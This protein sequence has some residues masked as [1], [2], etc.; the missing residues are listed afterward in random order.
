MQPDF[1]PAP[2]PP[3]D[4]YAFLN[5]TKRPSPL[6]S[7]LA[8]LSTRGKIVLGVGALILLIILLVVVKSILGS[9]AKSFNLTSLEGVLAQQQQIITLATTGSQQ[10]QVTSQSYMNFSYTAIASATTD[11]M[12]LIKLLSYNGVKVNPASYTFTTSAN[13]KLTQAGQTSTFDSLYA[14]VMAQ[15]LK[16]YQQALSNAYSLNKSTI[17]K[18]YL[19][20]DYKNTAVLIKMLGSSYG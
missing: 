13:T 2:P 8:N 15:Q 18:N 12:K 5:Q 3:S 10:Q 1:N 11:Q 4:P 17:V 7:S 19:T 6:A 20:A 9:G 14:A 16:A